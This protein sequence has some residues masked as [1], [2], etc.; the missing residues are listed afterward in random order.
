MWMSLDIDLSEGIQEEH[1][2]VSTVIQLLSR[3]TGLFNS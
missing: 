2:Y 3:I 1:V